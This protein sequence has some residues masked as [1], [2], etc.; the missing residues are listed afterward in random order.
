MFISY[1]ATWDI[2]MLRCKT[3]FSDKVFSQLGLIVQPSTMAFGGLRYLCLL[4]SELKKELQGCPQFSEDVYK[5]RII[6]PA[7]W[8]Q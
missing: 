5:Q 1:D 7:I 2:K 8:M 6:T 4:S 3:M